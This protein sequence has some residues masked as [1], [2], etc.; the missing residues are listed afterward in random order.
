MGYLA[1]DVGAFVISNIL[2]D[3]FF[4][5]TYAARASKIITPITTPAIQANVPKRDPGYET[6]TRVRNEGITDGVRILVPGYEGI[7]AGVRGY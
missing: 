2:E 3:F 6:I 7:R 4:L 5:I 1:L